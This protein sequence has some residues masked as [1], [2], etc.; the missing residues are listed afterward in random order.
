MRSAIFVLS[1]ATA[2]QQGPV[3]ALVSTAGW[4]SAARR[5]LGEGGDASPL[6]TVADEE[7]R[8]AME[9]G[10]G[11]DQ[12]LDGVEGAEAPDPADDELV[13]DAELAP[14]RVAP[15]LGREEVEVDPGRRDQHA[16]VGDAQLADLPRDLVGAARDEIG[17]VERR[18]LADALQPPTPA[19]SPDP[20]L[21]GLPHLRRGDEEDRGDTETVG[22]VQPG[23][24]E[25]LVALPYERDVVP[26]PRAAG[27]D[28]G[29]TT[30][31]PLEHVASRDLGRHRDES[32]PRPGRRARQVAAGSG[33]AG[34][35]RIEHPGRGRD[36][37]LTQHA[38]RRC[39]PSGG[40]D[41]GGDG[42]LLTGGG[43]G[44]DEDRRAHAREGSAPG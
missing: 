32:R 10:G 14:D 5:V 15:D 24:V 23:G 19:R 37:G 6:G 3:A 18:P 12:L 34:R 38:L 4:A 36:P 21:L 27:L 9:P 8:H 16:V 40:A 35:L 39:G 41:E 22:E 7:Q 30:S 17:A 13:V 33:A 28:G 43:A 20:P 2:R 29:P 44:E 42:T 11:L 1:G 31:V 26:R 25:H